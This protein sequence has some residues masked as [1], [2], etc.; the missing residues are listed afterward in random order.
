MWK[1]KVWTDATWAPDYGTAYDN[2]RSTTGWIC[3]LGGNAVSW[4]SH[5][6]SVVAHSSAESE[7]FAANDGAKEAIY[8]RRIFEDLGHSMYGPLSMMVDNQTAIKQSTTTMD[9][10]TSR[11]IGLKQHYLRQQCNEGTLALEYVN[12]HDQLADALTKCLPVKQHEELRS[13]IGVVSSS[14]FA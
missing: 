1:A 4:T 7:W 6:Q 10:K 11:H 8:V 12:T 9:L 13:R 2:Y 14:I 5:R 3:T